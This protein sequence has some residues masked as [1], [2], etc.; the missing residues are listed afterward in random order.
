M[1]RVGWMDEYSAVAPIRDGGSHPNE[2]GEGGEMWNFREED[3]YYYGYVMSVNFAGLDLKKVSPDWD[4]EKEIDNVDIVFFAKDDNKQNVVVGWYLDATL[5]HKEY[6]SRRNINR[7]EEFRQLRYLAEVDSN[8][9][10]LLPNNDRVFHVPYGGGLPGQSNVWYGTEKTPAITAYKNELRDYI[11]QHNPNTPLSG[12]PGTKSTK[13][14]SKPDK[15]LILAIEKA[16][17]VMTRKFYEDKEYTVLS[18]ETENVGWDLEATKGDELLLVEVKGH[19]GNIIQFEL[20]P[21]EYKK[22]QKHIDQYRVC[23]VRNA[24]SEPDLTEFSAFQYE[25]DDG[26][27]LENESGSEIVRLDE[28]VSAKAIQIED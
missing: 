8:S 2:T 20:T 24:L 25:D 11:A 6:R 12:S 4:G 19:Q 21:N 27:Y 9:A 28:R 5:Y 22:L 1:F 14:K 17:V 13:K 3:G 18:V 10:L 26:Y 23:I 15:A 7:A 16:A